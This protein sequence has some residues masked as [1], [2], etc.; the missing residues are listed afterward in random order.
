VTCVGN[1]GLMSTM[2][3]M[4]ENQEQILQQHQTIIYRLDKFEF[5]KT[6]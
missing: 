6:L 1:A 5:R 2:E 3:R 4:L